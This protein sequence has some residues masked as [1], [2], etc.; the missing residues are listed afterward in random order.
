MSRDYVTIY[1]QKF[2]VKSW[3]RHIYEKSGCFK[4]FTYQAENVINNKP[5]GG[6]EN[7]P[8]MWIRVKVK[9]YVMIKK[10]QQYN[11]EFT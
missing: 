3:V 10:K 4:P 1:N 8:P 2:F 9:R 6:V 11:Y 7:T 5:R